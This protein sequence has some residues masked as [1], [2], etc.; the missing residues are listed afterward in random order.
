MTKRR[1]LLVVIIT[2]MFVC[3]FLTGC[4]DSDHESKD[5][6]DE[7]EIVY[8]CV[9]PL[10]LISKEKIEG[11]DIK[12][13]TYYDPETMIMFV[14]YSNCNDKGISVMHNSDGTPRIYDGVS[15]VKPLILISKEDIVDTDTKQ[16][17]FY[18]PETLVM[19]VRY[20]NVSCCGISEMPNP[21]GNLRTYNPKK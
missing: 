6:E 4:D 1:N 9:A 20:T 15:E 10:I 16:Y 5:I 17:T 13:Y 12:Q 11:S 7:E 19:Y 21:D 2:L 3:V 8:E 14:H 18:D